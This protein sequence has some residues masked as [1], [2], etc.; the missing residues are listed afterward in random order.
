MQALAHY[1][2]ITLCGLVRNIRRFPGRFNDFDILLAM[3]TSDISD[4]MWVD[5]YYR[6]K[7][8]LSNILLCNIILFLQK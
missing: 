6:K 5:V 7:W 3:K 8:L 4:Y 2:F 1:V